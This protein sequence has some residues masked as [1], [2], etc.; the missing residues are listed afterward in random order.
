[1]LCFAGVHADYSQAPDIYYSSMDARLIVS[2][3]RDEVRQ[4]ADGYLL[5]EYKNGCSECRGRNCKHLACACAM[6][7]DVSVYT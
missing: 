4:V 3:I 2:G 5:G 1:V 7:V 6:H